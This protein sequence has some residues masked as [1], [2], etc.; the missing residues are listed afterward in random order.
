M[1]FTFHS[2]VSILELAGKNLEEYNHNNLEVV[3]TAT[4]VEGGGW[5]G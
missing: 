5:Q 4:Q 1:N 2:W 3:L